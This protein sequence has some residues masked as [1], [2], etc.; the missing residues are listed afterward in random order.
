MKNYFEQVYEIVAQIPAGKIATYGQIAT[1]LC[2]P[3]NARIVGFAMRAVPPQMELPC[4]RVVKS[5]GSLGGYFGSKIEEKVEILKAEG[6]L[7]KNSKIID[8]E[9]VIWK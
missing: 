6:I 1:I 5:D 8:F 4:H 9:K 3:K 7:V 2:T